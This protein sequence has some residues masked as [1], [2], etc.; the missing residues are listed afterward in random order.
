MIFYLE[1]TFTLCRNRK[2]AASR[3]LILNSGLSDFTT[4]GN[5]WQAPIPSISD[6]HFEIE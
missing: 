5:P 2:P 3:S 6:S 4:T 1:A